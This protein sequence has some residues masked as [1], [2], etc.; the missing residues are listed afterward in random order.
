M[1]LLPRVDQVV[2]LKVSQLSETLLAQ[3]ALKRSLATVHAEMDL[4]EHKSQE[5]RGGDEPRVSDGKT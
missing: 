4:Q 3:V 1:R 2:L 5:G